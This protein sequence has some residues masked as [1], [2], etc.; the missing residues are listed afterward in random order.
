MTDLSGDDLPRDPDLAH[1]PEELQLLAALHEGQV[2]VLDE[3]GVSRD[4]L[5]LVPAVFGRHRR[6]KE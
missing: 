1:A 4:V 2:V 6:M 5:V 3:S